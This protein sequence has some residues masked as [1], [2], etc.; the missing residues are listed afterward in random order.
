MSAAEIPVIDPMWVDPEH[1]ERPDTL[2]LLLPHDTD[3]L[4]HL[5]ASWTGMRRVVFAADGIDVAGTHLPLEELLRIQAKWST[6]V[7][8][9]RTS[10]I[11]L[12]LQMTG[13]ELYALSQSLTGVVERLRRGHTPLWT[14]RSPRTAAA[15]DPTHTPVD[16]RWL[17]PWSEPG[18]SDRLHIRFPS[19][20]GYAYLRLRQR[21]VAYAVGGGLV[22]K[23]IDAVRRVRA[24]A[25]HV[26]ILFDDAH[27]SRQARM[28]PAERRALVHAIRGF[29]AR[30]RGDATQPPEALLDM[31]QD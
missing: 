2:V 14:P 7:F 3:W 18:L 12:Q 13:G 23:S 15:D 26:E 24:R 25:D 21:D 20:D 11:R 31:L 22:T 5:L 4:S 10:E 30:N 29:V 28:T 6:L 1:R 8:S 27:W 9:T 19:D 17:A 16:P